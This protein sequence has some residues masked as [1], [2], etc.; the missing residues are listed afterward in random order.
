MLF[1]F[2]RRQNRVGY[3]QKGFPRLAAVTNEEVFSEI[4]EEGDEIWFG[5]FYR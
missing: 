5:S 2:E 1:T 4:H 3:E